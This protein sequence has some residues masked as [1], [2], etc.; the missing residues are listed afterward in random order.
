MSATLMNRTTEVQ[1]RHTNGRFATQTRPEATLAADSLV[2][3][4]LCATC[5]SV[6]DGGEALDECAI[7][8]GGTC[9]LSPQDCGCASCKSH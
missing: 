6:R 8:T 3:C 4:R 7:V 9:V 2:Q 1:A 5:Q